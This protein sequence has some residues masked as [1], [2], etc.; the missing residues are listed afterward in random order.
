MLA[1]AEI[2]A[3][4]D[5]A[6]L[7]GHVLLIEAPSGVQIDPRTAGTFM[8]EFFIGQQLGYESITDSLYNARGSMRARML[9]MLPGDEN[10]AEPLWEPV[11]VVWHEGADQYRYLIASWGP[12]DV[13]RNPPVDLSERFD[14][15]TRRVLR[16]LAQAEGLRI[17]YSAMVCTVRSISIPVVALYGQP[18]RGN[19]LRSV[20]VPSLLYRAVFNVTVELAADESSFV[21]LAPGHWCNNPSRVA[22]PELTSGCSARMR[23]QPPHSLHPEVCEAWVAVRPQ[24]D[25]DEAV[26]LPAM[27]RCRG[28]RLERRQPPLLA[29]SGA[30]GASVQLVPP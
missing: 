15:G 11:P 28:V 30:P 17:E 29:G 16:S 1:A 3:V 23:W 24:A 22:P 12:S 7:L 4:E 21:F 20:N 6:L 9:R 14:P 25:D 18:V 10:T 5:G 8:G 2:A 19:D 13:A 27:A 26:R